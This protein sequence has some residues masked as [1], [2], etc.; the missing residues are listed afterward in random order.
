MVYDHAE[1]LTAF[2]FYDILNPKQN[3]RYQMG[4]LLRLGL[5]E[6]M[7][8]KTLYLASLLTIVFLVLLVAATLATRGTR[9][10]PGIL[11]V[12]TDGDDIN[13]CSPFAERCRTVQRAINVATTGDEIRVA[14]GV[15]T[16]S[17]YTVAEI[18]E[19]ITLQGGW[20]T[21]F[22]TQDPSTY[23]TTLDAQSLGRVIQITG[24]ISPTI[25]GFII[26]GGNATTEADYSR[27]GGGIYAID[28]APIIVNNVITNNI[29]STDPNV[30][31]Y[32]GGCLLSYASAPAVVSGNQILSNTAST[33]Y[34]GGGGGLYLN[35]SDATLT[36]NTIRHNTGSTAAIGVGGGLYFFGSNAT[37]DGN[38]IIS[39]TASSS[40]GGLF[41]SRSALT[42]TNN[43]IA[44][45]QAN[46]QAG[47]IYIWGAIDYP[48][49]GTL[50]NNTIA[51]NN[52]G[53]DG[54]GVYATG[55]TSLTL[56]NNI[57]VSHSY[58]I[59]IGGDATAT[60]D[61][62]LFFSNPSGDTVGSVTSTH[63][64][65]GDPLF[66]NPVVWDYHIQ[67]TSPAINNGTFSGAPATDFEGDPRPYDCF[68][69]LGADENTASDECKRIY[70][71]LIMKNY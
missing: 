22:S 64:V 68:I 57:I 43:I 39:N 12:A 59:Y 44:Q 42:L 15:Y 1:A 58:G 45:N 38:L 14:T 61:Y 30:W 34:K 63:E 2:L 21:G 50:I 55:T 25:D 9:A 4:R 8:S 13:D 65:S 33:D 36:G 62:T 46:T 17:A 51:Q 35:N 20:N 27:Q 18:T 28:A 70:L 23:P 60:A 54:E 47:G 69:D 49:S 52:L 6:E 67:V 32:G 10:S 31:G 66:V 37:L 48:S 24:N 7:R 3:A 16:D 26:T 41:V 71:P 5:E 29:A 11:Y 40:G 56:T 53:S 19:T